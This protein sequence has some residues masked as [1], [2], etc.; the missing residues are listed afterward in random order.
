MIPCYQAYCGDCIFC[1]HPRSNLCT[2]V[3]GGRRLGV[4]VRGCGGGG[5]VSVPASLGGAPGQPW[6]PLW[7]PPLVPYGG[8][9]PW[10]LLQP[11]SAGQIMGQAGPELLRPELRCAA[12]LLQV[13]AFTGAGKMKA[14]GGVR[15]HCRGQPIY[16]FMG[17]STFAGGWA[18]S[19]A[20]R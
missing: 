16:H 9:G 11:T 19:C 13:R 6:L 1:K 10:A 8:G 14:D 12:P 2:S 15:F 7:L 17:T 4:G 18:A 5:V 20:V 3:R